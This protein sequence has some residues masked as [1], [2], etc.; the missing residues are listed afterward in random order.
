MPG[1]EG[2][3]YDKY[4]KDV[5]EDLRDMHAKISSR[6]CEYGPDNG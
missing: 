3:D 6:I 2:F 5:R 1:V 4:D